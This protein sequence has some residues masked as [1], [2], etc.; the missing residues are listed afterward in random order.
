MEV[1]LIYLGRIC[2]SLR[3]E[4]VGKPCYIRAID[5]YEVKEPYGATRAERQDESNSSEGEV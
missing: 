3:G 5:G 2:W 4:G 1:P